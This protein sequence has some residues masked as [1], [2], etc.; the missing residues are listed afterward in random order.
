MLGVHAQCG[1]GAQA[2]KGGLESKETRVRAS[3]AWV[4]SLCLPGA[5]MH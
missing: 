5:G 4:S 1:G 2:V 3:G